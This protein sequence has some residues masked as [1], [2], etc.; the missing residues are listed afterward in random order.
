[1]KPCPFCG[2]TDLYHGYANALAAHVMCY[3]CGAR[4]T[5]VYLSDEPLRNWE[6]CLQEAVEL[7]NNREESR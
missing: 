6:R 4:T 5:P 7:W 3:A 1:M 2:G